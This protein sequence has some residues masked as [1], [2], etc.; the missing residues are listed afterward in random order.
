MKTTNLFLILIFLLANT[1]CKKSGSNQNNSSLMGVWTLTAIQNVNT[2]QI[3]NY[4][5]SIPKKESIT[6]TDS[7]SIIKIG[8]V[9]NTGWC[10]YSING[11][12]I[13]ISSMMTTKFLCKDITWEDYLLFNLES[14]FLFILYGDQL[15]IR[16]SGSFNL[17]F[18]KKQ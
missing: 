4:P 13:S 16:S 5:D 6:I 9:C 14:A 2:C 3:T 7:S 10:T 18:K 17:I 1:E 15:I 8:G 12:K 11:N